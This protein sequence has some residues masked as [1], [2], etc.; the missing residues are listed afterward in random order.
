M[1]RNSKAALWTVQCQQVR[2]AFGERAELAFDDL[3]LVILSPR[4]FHLIKHDLVTAVST[5]GKL[6]E[7]QGHMIKMAGR[8]ST[9]SWK[10]A[11]DDILWKLCERCGCSLLQEEPFTE[12]R[13]E[14]FLSERASP[15]QVVVAGIPM[16]AG[17]R[18]AIECS[19]LDLQSTAGCILTAS[20]KS[21]AVEQQMHLQ[22]R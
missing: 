18:G 15:A 8:T 20:S 2:L 21:S 22:T 7:V 9:G 12:L 10:D 11:L 14:R 3:Y 1:A 19:K 5:R 6:T 4:G 16:S 13:F 17:R